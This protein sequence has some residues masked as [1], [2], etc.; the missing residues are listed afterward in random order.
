V[1]VLVANVRN[2]AIQKSI[3]MIQHVVNVDARIKE[4]EPNVYPEVLTRSG[5]PKHA[6]ANV[7]KTSKNQATI[8]NI[9]SDHHISWL[10]LHSGILARLLYKWCLE[11]FM[12]K[13]FSNQYFWSITN[14]YLRASEHE[15]QA[16]RVMLE[17]GLR[18]FS[19][20]KFAQLSLPNA[21][22]PTVQVRPTIWSL[23]KC[24]ISSMSEL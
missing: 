12:Q 4:I 7:Q 1:N 14:F 17:M 23:Q 21:S 20:Y 11:F 3:L 16:K 5:I 13:V 10:C 22:S 19:Q 15:A 8:K 24:S 18:S 2:I 9:G 6:A